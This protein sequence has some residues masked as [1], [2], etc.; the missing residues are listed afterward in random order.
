MPY[1]AFPYPEL[2]LLYYLV[3]NFARSAKL[4]TRLLPRTGYPMV[5]EAQ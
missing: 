1:R 2:T 4:H 5:A 3:C